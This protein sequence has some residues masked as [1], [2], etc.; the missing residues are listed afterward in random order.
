MISSARV[1]VARG[2]RAL[3]FRDVTQ[4]HQKR[5]PS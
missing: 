4:T 1:G 5:R 2:V 3:N